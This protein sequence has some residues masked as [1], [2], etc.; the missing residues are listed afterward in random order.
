MQWQHYNNLKSNITYIEE[1]LREI[2]S[3]LNKKEKSIYKAIEVDLTKK[4]INS[5]KNC[6]KKIYSDLKKAKSNF[7]LE[8]KPIKSSKIIDANTRFIWITV[9]DT[10][11][12][13]MEKACG[14]ITSVEKK[15]QIDDLLKKILKSTNK[16]RKIAKL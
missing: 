7:N 15:K 16:I 14:K 9:E 4:Q 13:K 8:V 2:E 5:I 6:L 12:S 1:L 11:P 10:W 3:S